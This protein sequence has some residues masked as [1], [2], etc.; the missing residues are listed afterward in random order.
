VVVNQEIKVAQTV[1]VRLDRG[2]HGK[3]ARVEAR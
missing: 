1:K 3:Q 2:E